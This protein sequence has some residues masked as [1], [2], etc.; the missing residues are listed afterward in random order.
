MTLTA[1]SR[2]ARTCAILVIIAATCAVWPEAMVADSPTSATFLSDPADGHIKQNG[3]DGWDALRISH[4]PAEVY[5]DL[6]YVKINTRT[7]I[8][9]RGFLFFDTSSLPD[10]EPLTS[11]RLHIYSK[12]TGDLDDC[13][14]YILAGTLEYPHKPL[15]PEDY[16]L[17]DEALSVCAQVDV[18][19][20]AD[21]LA[22]RT[23][24]LDNPQTVVNTN[25]V[26]K[27]CLLERRDY[28]G[29]SPPDPKSE[30]ELK[31]YSFEEGEGFQPY[32]EVFWGGPMPAEATNP[33][34]DA[35]ESDASATGEPG[36]I[37]IFIGVAAAVAVGSGIAS[38]IARRRSRSR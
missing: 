1:Q 6:R 27:L 22:Y 21:K 35:S 2:L 37:P 3:D 4:E 17:P 7:N 9:Y 24:E 32:L 12:C 23:V 20:W 36:R 29:T 15:V 18:G 34:S 13:G 38:L 5:D 28:E 16:A 11:A 19:G 14:L 31:L 8:I 33:A 26:T 30:N 10:S 25:G